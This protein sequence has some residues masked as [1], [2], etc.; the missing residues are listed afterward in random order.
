MHFL[1]QLLPKR[2]IDY[3]IEHLSYSGPLLTNKRLFEVVRWG[4]VTFQI[5]YS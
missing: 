4:V 1:K 3:L 2:P 5:L